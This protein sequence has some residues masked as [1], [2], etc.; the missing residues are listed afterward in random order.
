[1]GL[2]ASQGSV[3]DP[4]VMLMSSSGQAALSEMGVLAGM[5]VAL[6]VF[7]TLRT[8]DPK[9]DLLVRDAR[10][11]PSC[12]YCP[13]CLREHAVAN[14]ELHWRFVPWRYCPIHLCLMEERCPHC[15]GAVV[16]PFAMISS[17]KRKAGVASL[18]DCQYC[19]G[20]LYEVAPIRLD[21]LSITEFDEHRLANGR[22]LMAALYRG[23]LHVPGRGWVRADKG[24][25]YVTIATFS[26]PKDWYKPH[27]VR[28]RGTDH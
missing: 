5:P 7:A 19:S 11:N 4:D 16:L 3:K 6:R 2:N 20:R 17:G 9:G 1:M 10:G 22:A 18:S 27:E 12:R 26:R 8:F 25:K 28:E 24:R 13:A 21:S 23:R 15:A 14:F